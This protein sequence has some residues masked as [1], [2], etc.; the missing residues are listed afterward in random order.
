MTVA[1]RFW[2]NVYESLVPA[3]VGARK[4]IPKHGV[5]HPRGAGAVPSLGLPVGQLR[6]WRFPP[7]HCCRGLHVHEYSDRWEGHLDRVHP[8][9]DPVD[10]IRRDAPELWMTGG[11]ALGAVAGI[12]VA[13]NKGA[14]ALVG[15]GL[16]L[17]L[18]A[19]TLS[20]KGE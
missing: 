5:P 6:D 7:D 16:G 17:L 14:G 8:N 10:H 4:A 11:A 19:A 3:A 2:K 12:A 13:E 20:K 15:A 9:C 1:D 18:A